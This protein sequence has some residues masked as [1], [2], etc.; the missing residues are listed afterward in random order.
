M[1][2][3]GRLAFSST[4]R[5][6]TYGSSEADTA[7]WRLTVDHHEPT[8]PVSVRQTRW[9]GARTSTS[10]PVRKVAADMVASSCGA[11][12]AGQEGPTVRR[13][14]VG[15]GARPDDVDASQRVL[16][17]RSRDVSGRETSPAPRSRGRQGPSGSS[18]PSPHSCCCAEPV[19]P[20]S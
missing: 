13:R 6:P 12:Q 20:R 11:H 5:P 3:H 2:P 8:S 10:C 9:T 17:D 14:V 16:R 7:P 19:C 15:P 1:V 4:T 18:A